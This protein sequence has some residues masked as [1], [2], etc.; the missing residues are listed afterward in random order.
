MERKSSSICIKETDKSREELRTG[1]KRSVGS[2]FWS[3]KISLI[4]DQ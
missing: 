3:T 2:D 4:S 1:E